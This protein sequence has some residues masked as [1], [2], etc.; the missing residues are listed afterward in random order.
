MALWHF[1]WPSKEKVASTEV[2]DRFTTKDTKDTKNT[3]RFKRSV[4]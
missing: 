2:Q 3:I 4:L 1:E